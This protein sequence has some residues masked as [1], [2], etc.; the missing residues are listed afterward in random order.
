MYLKKLYSEPKGLFKEVTFKN[1]V[2]FIFGQKDDEANPKASLNSIGKSTFLDL[3]DFC[4]LASHIRAHNP[5]LFSASNII[6]SY[7]I[8]LEF[9]IGLTTYCIKRKF[10]EPKSILLRKANE[11]FIEYDIEKAKIFLGEL[12]FKRNDYEGVFNPKWFRTLIGFY[13]KIQKF[14]KEQFNDP[15]KFNKD[16]S[17]AELVIYHLY[18]LGL[19]NTLSYNNFKHLT[20]LKRKK[21]AIAE[22]K[23][24][25]EEKFS[26]K[27]FKQTSNSINKLRLEIKKLDQIISTFQLNEQYGEAESE[28]NAYTKQIKDKWFENFSDRK[29][30]ESYQAS[31]NIKEA[32]STTK[33]KNLYKEV[34]DNFA[35]YVKAT[36]DDALKFRKALSESRRS[37][38]S[39]EITQLQNCIT[40]REIEIAKLE[41]KRAVLFSFL[42]AQEAIKDLTEA[43][44]VI[45]EKR[46]EL[47]ALEANF[48]TYNDLV[49]ERNEIELEIKR[50]Q[51]EI[52][53]FINSLD[54]QISQ[55]Y[56]LFTEIYNAIYLSNKNES[57]FTLDYYKNA[58]K[59]ID[60]KI[61]LPDMYG[62]GKNQGRTLIYDL[63]I[64]LNNLHQ[65]NF[66]QFIVHDGIFDGVD[67]AHF[68]SIYEYVEGLANSGIK[69]QY[70]TTI[71][72]EG[73]LSAKFGQSDIIDP[74][75]IA[76]QAIL[77]LTP[78]KK[79]L[80]VNFDSSI[81]SN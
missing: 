79:L 53:K 36:L 78:S 20:D 4:L 32:I 30:I 49:S 15:I 22:L 55:F 68:L 1:G 43:F 70:I 37:F 6:S 8:A 46:N 57:S 77:V 10:S 13:L 5:R 12:I 58:D 27:D 23:R 66:P 33:I 47:S 81:E 9:E 34:S 44:V 63:F 41:Q 35:D 29:K 54:Q 11:E 24:L 42:S 31:F 67:K 72:E 76:E 71:N 65:V 45:S 40:S 21:P 52:M 18:L 73:T 74:E 19:D 39:V 25:I 60:I 56:E 75:F 64:V 17:E 62:K 7:Y 59:L 16:L 51:N 50:N 61:N 28:A 38:L 69:I 2:N 3:L 26:L 14:K 80:G 48:K